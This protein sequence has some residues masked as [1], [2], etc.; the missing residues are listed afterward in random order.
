MKTCPKASI[1]NLKEDAFLRSVKAEY[2]DYIIS[3]AFALA[4]MNE[5]VARMS[6]AATYRQD[7]RE[8]RAWRQ[9]GKTTEGCYQFLQ[10][11]V[12]NCKWAHGATINFKD[13]R[14]FYFSPAS[15]GSDSKAF[16]YGEAE[17]SR[18]RV[19]TFGKASE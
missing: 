15:F 4:K 12:R 19:V 6:L 1:S 17:F 14:T 3:Q 11:F 8:P 2:N 16:P 5:G 9:K 18:L 10:R 13:D 7:Y